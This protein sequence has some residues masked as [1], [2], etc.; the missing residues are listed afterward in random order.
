MF[1][2]SITL[3]ADSDPDEIAGKLESEA[4]HK[5]GPVSAH[6]LANQVRLVVAGLVEHGTKLEAIGSHFRASRTVDGSGFRVK[7]NYGEHDVGWK[8]VLAALRGHG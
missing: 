7:V 4:A 6:E 5:I 8:R 1:K 3:D 2:S